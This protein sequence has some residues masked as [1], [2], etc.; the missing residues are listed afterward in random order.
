MQANHILFAEHLRQVFADFTLVDEVFSDFDVLTLPDGMSDSKVDG[1]VEFFSHFNK[2]TLPFSFE[3]T[4]KVWWNL[5]NLNQWV[6]DGDGYAELADPNDT[7]ILRIRLAVFLWK[8]YVEGE[9][10]LTGTYLEETG[11][12]RLQPSADEDSTIVAGI[13]KENAEI[14]TMRLTNKLL[15]DTFGTN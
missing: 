7:V 9:G 15:E 4:H 1:A 3:Q 5:T 12:A 13:L 8:T 11:W 10:P 14:I 6:Q 2:C